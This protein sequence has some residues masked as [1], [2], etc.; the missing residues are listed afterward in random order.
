M[1]YNLFKTNTT[2][3]HWMQTADRI[4]KELTGLSVIETLYHPQNK[5][6]EPFIHNL[7]THSAIFIF[8][9]SLGQLLI[10]RNILPD[11]VLGA[12]LGEFVACVFAGALTFEEALHLVVNQAQMLSTDCPSGSMLAII[13]SPLIYEQNPIFANRCDLAAI[14]FDS[15][16]VI[17]GPNSGI[18]TVQK[19]LNDHEISNQKLTVNMGYHSS[20]IDSIQT[21]YL[22]LINQQPYKPLKLRFIACSSPDD[23]L[24]TLSPE[25][26][27]K[28]VRQPIFFQ[29][30]IQKLEKEGSYEYLD[31]GPSGTLATFAKYNLAPSST[32][33]II[34]L[35]TPFDDAIKPI[36]S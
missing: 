35:M 34:S 21:M 11:I 23:T 17:S 13:N 4:H 29:K 27:W 12:S 33:Q 25:H 26:F 22:K 8:E 6:S 10:E 7:L 24:T 31:V 5:K 9:Y 15:H 3:R 2:F 1:G 18:N 20:C 19:Y 28:T 14:N 30:A 32:S 16:F 36:L